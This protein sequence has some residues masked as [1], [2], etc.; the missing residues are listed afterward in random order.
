MNRETVWVAALLLAI[1][2]VLI[3]VNLVLWPP[4]DPVGP[5]PG[6]AMPGVPPSRPAAPARSAAGPGAP[7]S[8]YDL[9]NDPD[10]ERAIREALARP[11][12]EYGPSRPPTDAEAKEFG[13]LFA[14]MLAAAREPGGDGVRACFDFRR[15]SEERIRQWAALRPGVPIPLRRRAAWGLSLHEAIDYRIFSPDPMSLPDAARVE[16]VAPSPDG[17]EAV[18]AVRYTEAGRGSVGVMRWRLARREAGWRAF[19]LARPGLWMWFAAS[20]V[21]PEK[22]AAS[23]IGTDDEEVAALVQVVSLVGG[24]DA[25]LVERQLSRIRGKP[26][27]PTL[28]AWREY[29]EGQLRLTRGRPAEAV[30]FLD[31]AVVAD[32]LWP[33]AY[34]ARATAF[35]RLGKPD[36]AL[37]DARRVADLVGPWPEAAAQEAEALRKLGEPADAAGK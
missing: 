18:V 17:R 31:A 15:Y 23:L 11:V 6:F 8:W 29:A 3:G 37:A 27:A 13:D 14:R 9:A 20:K 22:G 30:P 2:A 35:N 16:R 24:P 1:V 32:P 28:V 12:V 33:P 7:S 19:D 34:V 26:L 5:P 36:R 10:A 4:R 25:E 21:E